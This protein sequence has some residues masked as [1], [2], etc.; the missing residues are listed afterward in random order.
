MLDACFS[1]YW[2]HPIIEKTK[3]FHFIVTS[4]SKKLTLNA[5]VIHY[6]LSVSFFESDVSTHQLE[7]TI[8]MTWI[9]TY[10]WMIRIDGDF[11]VFKNSYLMECT[12]TVGYML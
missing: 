8:T 4:D 10:E 2:K 7:R 3:T 12:L 5:V 11:A 1:E 6:Y 9:D